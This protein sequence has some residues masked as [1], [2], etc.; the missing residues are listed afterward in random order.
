MIDVS[1]EIPEAHKKA[2][3]EQGL[4]IISEGKLA[5]MINFSGFKSDLRLS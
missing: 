1:T 3:R 2:L 4:R 5:V